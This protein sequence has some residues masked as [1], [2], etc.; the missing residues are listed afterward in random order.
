MNKATAHATL[1]VFDC[2]SLFAV[3]HYLNIWITIEYQITNNAK[4]ISMQNYASVYLLLAMV[5]IIHFSSLAKLQG[6]IKA[7]A[8][9]FIITIFFALLL[10]CYFSNRT[11]EKKI[12]E[13]GYTYCP[14]KSQIMTFSEFK[15]YLKD[16]EIC[17]KYF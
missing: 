5:P 8:N 12:I 13:S 2:A 14:S 11:L 3:Y 10:I 6:K 17:E 7:W 15:A 1:L 16:S 9:R 4:T